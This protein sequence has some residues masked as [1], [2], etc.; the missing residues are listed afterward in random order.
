MS[1]S[2]LSLPL[3]AIGSLA[4]VT[5]LSA[6]SFEF[7]AGNPEPVGGSE[8]ESPAA[9]ETAEAEGDEETEDEFVERGDWAMDLRLTYTSAESAEIGLHGLGVSEVSEDT[10][11]EFGSD[12]VRGYEAVCSGTPDLVQ[13]SAPS[14]LTS[15]E[16]SVLA[17]SDGTGSVHIDQPDNSDHPVWMSASNGP[18]Q[19]GTWSYSDGVVTLDGVTMHTMANDGWGSLSGTIVCTE[20]TVA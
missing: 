20:N 4:C 16:T 11:S 10:A 3:L 9:E 8:E 14:D 17:G 15:S 1:T 2:R 7:S 5:F 19:H 13:V 6:C 12:P 18:N